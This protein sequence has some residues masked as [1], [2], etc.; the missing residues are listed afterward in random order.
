MATFINRSG[1]DFGQ[2]L[3]SALQQALGTIGEGMQKRNAETQLQQLLGQ[4]QPPQAQGQQ[5]TQ[6]QP[7]S[8]IDLSNPMQFAQAHSVISQAR[9]KDAADN[10]A[11]A[12]L[13]QQKLQ[14]KQ[15]LQQERFLHDREMKND[16]QLLEREDKLN[17]YEQEGMRFERLQE[18]FSPDLEDKFPSSFTVGLFTKDGELR[19]T[20]AS[21][22][23]PEAQEA[24]K[25]IAD[26]LTGAKD[27]F[28]ARVTNFDVQSYMKRLPTLIN[29][30]EGRRRVLR[31]LRLMN[32]LNTDHEAGV[33]EI[34]DQAGGPGS[35]S[36]SQAE[37]RYKKAH[38]RE[39]AEI[40]EEFVHPEKKQFSSLQSIDPKVYQGK[41]VID[42]ETGQK[43][44]SNGT[45]WIEEQ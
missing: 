28:G 5:G 12:Q 16:P 30:A 19:P 37:R 11:K 31:D 17:H 29:T 35:M 40:R 34:I 33:L 13:E 4:Q 10:W 26:N 1:P 38:A 22:L 42:E 15:G 21:Q 27:T 8:G 45:E 3:G 24:T 6:Q 18:L 7:S 25:L 20:I 36:I 43:F 39:L 44:K 9:G 41:T 23:S 32:K 14:G 2:Q